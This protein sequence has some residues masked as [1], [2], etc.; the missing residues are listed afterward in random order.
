LLVLVGFFCISRQSA[1]EP[2]IV[3]PHDPAGDEIHKTAHDFLQKISDGDADGAKALFA[4]PADHEALLEAEVRFFA[5]MKKFS[6]SIAAKGEFKG[7]LRDALEKNL[8][9]N[10]IE[11]QLKRPVIRN[12]DFASVCARG[13]PDTGLDLQCIDGKWKVI[14][15]TCRFR[16]TAGPTKFYTEMRQ[17][18]G[19]VKS[20]IDAGKP[21]SDPEMVKACDAMRRRLNDGWLFDDS[22]HPRA[23]SEAERPPT[24]QPAP[25]LAHL[26]TLV[27]KPLSDPE[28]Q[29]I[30]PSLGGLP[31]MTAFHDRIYIESY[32]TG[33]S[34]SIAMPK[35]ELDAIHV[36]G[37]GDPEY[38]PFSGT[39]PHDLRFGESR[40]AVEKSLGRPS[41]FG[42]GGSV[43]LNVTYP[44]LGLAV[45]YARPSGRDPL[46]PVC[47]IVIF[48]P[49]ATAPPP[50]PQ[51]AGGGPRLT[52]RLVIP[53]DNPDAMPAGQMADPTHALQPAT[54]VSR[55]VLIDESMI[56]DAYGPFATNESLDHWFFILNMTPQGA[57][58]LEEITAAHGSEKVA[59]VLD[60]K[61]LMAPVINGKISSHVSIDL[62][63]EDDRESG[64]KLV[65]SLR[66]VLYSLPENAHMK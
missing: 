54:A 58:K 9:H 49:D 6:A 43:P 56:A 8:L 53:A 47:R 64:R 45:D 32:E 20:L 39:L 15:L 7:E 23:V 65:N 10:T 28:V 22:I 13:T 61:I 41:F 38:F 25:D 51:P 17:V 66:D 42:G 21:D 26:E 37:P 5:D 2:R 31:R 16:E 35:G 1:A 48:A 30:V 36:Y 34:F 52:F 18:V 24:T 60:G 12:G 50:A 55:K 29:A 62:G 44:R 57:A 63:T 3:L 11:D 19:R 4:G 59:I 33:L 14:H 27:G 46:N 40:A